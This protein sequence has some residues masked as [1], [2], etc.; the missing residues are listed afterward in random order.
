M[1]KLKAADSAIKQDSP[2]PS[3]FRKTHMNQ[4]RTL[5]SL[6]P[7]FHLQHEGF[8]SPAT[9]HRQ[10]CI[11]NHFVLHSGMRRC[12]RW[13]QLQ[14]CC[15]LQQSPQHLFGTPG[16]RRTWRSP[17]HQPQQTHAIR[18]RGGPKS[19]GQFWEAKLSSPGPS[20]ARG[21]QG[22]EM[23]TFLSM[24]RLMQVW[25]TATARQP[26]HPFDKRSANIYCCAMNWDCPLSYYI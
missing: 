24:Q 14:G 8:P 20:S 15:V 16:T 21:L 25:G 5:G 22:W 26:L 18:I 4:K 13:E 9:F 19:A 11:Y 3:Q 23:V 7:S 2:L 1:E 10:K 12:T 17:S 6:L